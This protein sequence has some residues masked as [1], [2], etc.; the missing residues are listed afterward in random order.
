MEIIG[1]F[2]LVDTFGWILLDIFMWIVNTIWHF[3]RWDIY[4]DF[5]ILQVPSPLVN[6]IEYKSYSSSPLGVE[7]GDLNKGASIKDV[8]F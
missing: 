2:G 8:R 5:E 7:Q 6:F 3:Y 4:F 1:E